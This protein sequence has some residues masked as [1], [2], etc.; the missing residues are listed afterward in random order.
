M[1]FTEPQGHMEEPPV[2]PRRSTRSTTPP[3]YT[4]IYSSYG[5]IILSEE[6]EKR[7]SRLEKR[8]V[9]NV[10]FDDQA[11]YY[12]GFGTDIYY[13]LGHL[14]WLQ[15]SNGVSADT[16]KEF[17]L[18]ILMTIA[19][20]LDDGVQSLSFRLEG[21]QQVVLYEDVRELLGFQKGASEK[22][23]VPPGMLDGFWNLISG[24]A[25]QQRNCIRNPIVRVFHSWMCKRVLGRMRETK[26]TDT[27]SN[28]LY[29]AL[30]AK[31]PIDPSYLMINRRCCE[32]TSGSGNIGSGFYLFM[33][34]F[35]LW[36][37]ITRNPE[38]L[39]RGTSLGIKYLRQGKY[40]SGD[41]REGFCLATVN[42]P[43]PD[44]RLRLF[45]EGRG[46]WLEEG[47]LVP[48][49]KNKRGRIVEEGTSSTQTSGAQ[50]NVPP[51]G[52]IP[53]PLSYYGGPQEQ[54]LGG[55]APVPP[56]NYVVPNVN[57]AEPYAQYSQP[58]QSVDIIGGYV[59]RNAQNV[60]AIQANAVQ[61]GEGN[62]NIAYELGRLHLVEPDQFVGGNVQ[63]YYEQGYYYQ[64]HQHQ[65]PAED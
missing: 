42:L 43:L 26:V 63:P 53:P 27:E 51:F 44:A 24:E 28:W 18:E 21:V 20:I 30:I 62:A 60:A 25:H 4:P 49:R 48:A 46:D 15:F 37:G 55:G 58:Q 54:A 23:D 41:E 13:M 32:A 5:F 45:I 57:F 50:P 10:E 36:P 33:L 16:N 14:G 64:D 29:S 8:L 12:L 61:L 1:R 40:I 39:L 38:H 7:L 35:S 2:P 56:P 22:V 52:E 6:E 31:Q 9:P 17:A 65:P 11:L 59:A 47:L 19:S 34:A 3:P